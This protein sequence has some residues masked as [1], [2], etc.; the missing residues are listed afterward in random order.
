[1]YV[2][3]YVVKLQLRVPGHTYMSFISFFSST[4]FTSAECDSIKQ[5]LY[6]QLQTKISKIHTYID[7]KHDTVLIKIARMPLKI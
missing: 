3:I 4:D 6:Y 1:M 7:C 2:S 5:A